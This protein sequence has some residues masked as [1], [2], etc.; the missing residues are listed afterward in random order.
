MKPRDSFSGAVVEKTCLICGRR[1]EPRRK[2]S[3]EQFRAVVRCSPSCRKTR[4][5]HVDDAIERVIQESLSQ[6]RTSRGVVALS[7][8]EP[9]LRGLGY[10]AITRRRIHNAL[11]R[12][13]A[14]GVLDIMVKGRVVD[15]SDAVGAMHF[16]ARRSM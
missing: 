15:P 10:Q 11:R 1:I 16:R 5:N 3:E 12:L 13:A 7:S 8:L 14:R 2:W 9:A 4:L 6:V